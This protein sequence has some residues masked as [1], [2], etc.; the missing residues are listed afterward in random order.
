[1]LYDILPPLAFFLSLG[2]ILL[3]VGRVVMRIRRQ[4]FA[5]HVQSFGTTASF[6]SGSGG[7][8]AAESQMQQLLQPTQKSVHMI[9]TRVGL[10]ASIAVRARQDVAARWRS[11]RQAHRE[12]GEQKRQEKAL[13]SAAARIDAESGEG[14]RARR[15]SALRRRVHMAAPASASVDRPHTVVEPA[16]RVSLVQGG[17]RLTEAAPANEPAAA[18]ETKQPEAPV[19][20]ASKLRELG[21][22]G[23]RRRGAG[24]E[25]VLDEVAQAEVLLAA[26]DFQRIEDMLVPYIVNHPKDTK[27]YMLLGRSAL[28][29][30]AWGEAMEIFE[31][32]I[33]WRAE[34]EGAYA[35][36][37]YAA[38]KAGRFTRALQALQRAHDAEPGDAM[39]LKY[40]LNI[41]RKMDNPALQH[42]I[43]EKLATARQASASAGAAELARPEARAGK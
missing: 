42:S 27:A 35:A 1:M 14:G 32:V 12:W 34:E 20:S 9:R 23:L 19:V 37:G 21:R 39:V 13:M 10:L 18:A 33:A 4:Q 22:R 25:A 6:A 3:I 31:Q 40:L 24:R 38:F 26:G 8:A 7:R 29:R 28:G 16:R 11:W 5:T 36:L 15:F 43:L 30:E 2:G 17:E 41:A